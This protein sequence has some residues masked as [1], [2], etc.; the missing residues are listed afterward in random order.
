[1]I[2]KLTEEIE[3]LRE[4]LRL[5]ELECQQL[6]SDINKAKRDAV[7]ELVELEGDK[8]AKVKRTFSY[9]SNSTITEYLQQLNYKGVENV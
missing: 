5:K 9:V 2:V 6:H 3:A 7:N 8:A 4:Q 1:M